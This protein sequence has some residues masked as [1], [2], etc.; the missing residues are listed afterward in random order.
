MR[1]RTTLLAAICLAIGGFYCEPANA[2]TFD[3]SYQIGDS[4]FGIFASGVLTTADTQ[5]NGA[6]SIT[7]ITGSRTVTFGSSQLTQTIT[8]LLYPDTAYGAKNLLYVD[9]PY[10][11]DSGFTYTLEGGFGGDD[12]Q[13]DVNFAYFNGAYYEPIEGPGAGSLTLTPASAVPEPTS[14][15]LLA[16]GGLAILGLYRYRRSHV[17][18]G[19]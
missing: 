2:K 10:L 4:N 9:S 12:F 8:G 16:G 5:V 13:G 7:G 1:L 11:D 6:Y 19:S 15:G 18:L 17:R 3:F 14:W